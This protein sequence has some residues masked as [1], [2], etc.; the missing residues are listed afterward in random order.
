MLRVMSA[1]THKARN[2]EEPEKPAYTPSV[3][4]EALKKKR[5]E[6]EAK[7]KV[8][9]AEKKR[10]DDI[11]ITNFSPLAVISSGKIILTQIQG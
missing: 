8:E 4:Y 11:N 6:E 3:D 2:T 10:Q 9:E 1:M 5:E 7:R